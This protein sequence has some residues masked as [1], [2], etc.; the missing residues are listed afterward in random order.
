[1]S[2]QKIMD[3]FANQSQEILVLKASNRVLNS[4]IEN[5]KSKLRIA[6]EALKDAHRHACSCC[7]STY[8]VD[9]HCKE[10]LLKIGVTSEK[11]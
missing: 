4:E 6:V 5:L 1:M 7:D 3:M 11:D 10:A 2:D 8:A 9:E